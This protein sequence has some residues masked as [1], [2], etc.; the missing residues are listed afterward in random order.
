MAKNTDKF[1]YQVADTAQQLFGRACAERRKELGYTQAEL[2]AKVG[3]VTHMIGNFEAGKQNIAIRTLIAIFGCLDMHIE[4][5]AKDGD[6]PA[7]FPAVNK[8]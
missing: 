4:L 5:S 3:C 1:D 8:N 2:A 6:N 7:G